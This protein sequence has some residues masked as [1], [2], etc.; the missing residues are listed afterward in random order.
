MIYL[1]GQVSIATNGKTQHHRGIAN[2]AS[3]ERQ[4]EGII[5]IVSDEAEALPTRL[6]CCIE[7][8]A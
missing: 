5:D 6:L 2:E 7:A 4:Q 8:N 3:I 1:I